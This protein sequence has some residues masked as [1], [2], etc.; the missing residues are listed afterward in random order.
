[1]ESGGRLSGPHSKKVTNFLLDLLRA[2]IYSRCCSWM[3]APR[4]SVF[5]VENR[6]CKE[7]SMRR[8]LLLTLVS[9]MFVSLSSPLFSQQVTGTIK[10]V[11]TDPSGATIPNATVDIT[12]KAT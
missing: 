1:M 8:A 12:N 7:A 4:N 9:L 5:L 10:G 2:L 3:W 6:I 11:V